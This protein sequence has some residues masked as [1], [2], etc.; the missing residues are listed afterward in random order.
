MVM[1]SK[2]EIGK[3]PVDLLNKLVLDPI[4]NNINKRED[5]V[6]RPSTGEDCSAVD[7]GGEICV[8]STDPITAAGSNAGYLVVHINCNDAASAGAEPIGILLTILLPA[9][10]SEEDLKEIIDGAY[11]AARELGIEILGGHTEVTEAVNKPVVNGTVVAK[12]KGRKFISSGG[13]KSG[14]HIIMT[15]WAAIEGTSII[16]GDYEDKLKT[17]LSEDIINEAKSLSS[18]ISVVKEGIIASEYGATATHDATEGGIL[19]AVWEVAECS[20]VGVEIYADEIPVLECT[21]EICKAAK[22]DYLRL[23]SSGTLI[24]TAFDGEK[25]VDKLKSEGINAAVIGRVTDSGRYVTFN[26]IRKELMPQEKD[27]IYRVDL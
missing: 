26:G 23:I 11:K 9:G 22:I 24:M 3:V 2:L 1:G 19:G 18:K 10:S 25:L 7:P 15:K 4:N 14:Q 20:K 12:T 17:I 5:I 13:A 21:K 8:L 16:A 27:E 6:I